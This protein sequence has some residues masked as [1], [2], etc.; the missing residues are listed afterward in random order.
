VT[1]L[2][3]KATLKA[4]AREDGNLTWKDFK[5]MECLCKCR[6]KWRFCGSLL[7]DTVYFIYFPN[8]R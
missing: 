6:E 4:Q 7:E 2:E 5:D 1:L 3:L 8:G